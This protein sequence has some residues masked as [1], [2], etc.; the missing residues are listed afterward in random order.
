VNPVERLLRKADGT[1]QKY[2]P[3]AFVLGVVKKYGDDNGGVLV[4]NLTH[5]AFV[6]FFPAAAGACD[7]ARP[8]GGE[9]PRIPP[10]RG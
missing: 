9:R 1:Q 10:A 8:G 6:S 5:S 4:A 7:G 3:S 2:R